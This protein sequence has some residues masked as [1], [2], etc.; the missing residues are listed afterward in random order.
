MKRMVCRNGECVESVKNDPE[1]DTYLEGMIG[2]FDSM[3]KSAGL[4]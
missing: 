4:F 2:G 3:R 1:F